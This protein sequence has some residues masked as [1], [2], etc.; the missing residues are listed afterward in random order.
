MP[1]DVYFQWY[2]PFGSE[3][4]FTIYVHGDH[5]G[6]VTSTASMNLGPLESWRTEACLSYNLTDERSAQLS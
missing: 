3:E 1:D 5:I 4:G 6:D 2:R